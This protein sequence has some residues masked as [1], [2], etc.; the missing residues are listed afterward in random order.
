MFAF[1]TF[2]LI[3]FL[4]LHDLGECMMDFGMGGI[5]E[6]ENIFIYLHLYSKKLKPTLYCIVRIV[7]ILYRNISTFIESEDIV[8]HFRQ[9]S[10]NLLIGLRLLL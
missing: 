6:R 7:L 4:L 3:K 1:I 5:I 10:Y 9:H 8:Q 2:V